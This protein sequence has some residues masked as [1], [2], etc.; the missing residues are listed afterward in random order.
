MS[1]NKW[2][3]KQ[4][5]K[6]FNNMPDTQDTRTKEEVLTRLKLDNRLKGTRRKNPKRWMP[7]V[8]AAAAMIIFALILPS[9]LDREDEAS[10]STAV[11]DQSEETFKQAVTQ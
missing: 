5:K 7:A 10:D 3:E 11:M 4:I 2:D 1:T 9:M 6:V 8:V